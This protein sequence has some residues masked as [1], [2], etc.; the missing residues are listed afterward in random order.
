MHIGGTLS[1]LRT[2]VRVMHLAEILARTEVDR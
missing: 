2:G 1:R